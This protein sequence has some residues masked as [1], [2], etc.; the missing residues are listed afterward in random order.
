VAPGG[1]PV[2]TMQT[3][4]RL[5]AIDVGKKKLDVRYDQPIRCTRTACS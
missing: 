5:I 3:S 4:D 1:A 2:S